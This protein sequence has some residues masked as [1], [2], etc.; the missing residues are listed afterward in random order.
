[1]VAR[2]IKIDGTNIG[3]ASKDLSKV[4]VD[5]I[6][7]HNVI[8]GFAAYQKKSEFGPREIDV[9][10]LKAK[11]IKKEN[12][13]LLEK[14]SVGRLDGIVKRSQGEKLKKLLY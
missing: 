8:Y 5:D 11:Q 14:D 1:M 10:Q 12:L 2:N 7:L 6:D 13:F 4:L 3:V 9:Y